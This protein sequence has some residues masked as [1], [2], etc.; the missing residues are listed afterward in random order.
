VRS[1]RLCIALDI[2]AARGERG[3]FARSH[4]R[5]I[6]MQTDCESFAPAH[7]KTISQHPH[8]NAMRAHSGSRWRSTSSEHRAANEAREAS[9]A[10]SG[11]VKKRC[12]RG[13]DAPAF[14]AKIELGLTLAT[15]RICPA[16]R[17]R[18]QRPRASSRE[19]ITFATG[20][21]VFSPYC[22]LR[23]SLY[24]PPSTDPFPHE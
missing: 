1:S 6:A 23:G 4:P 14:V 9:R 22:I 3:R 7:R 8:I 21:T 20:V 16:Q 24:L 11:S 13:V 18:T 5:R 10:S 17:A 2:S 12:A 15:R 19:K